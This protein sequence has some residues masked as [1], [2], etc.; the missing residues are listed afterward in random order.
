MLSESLTIV[1]YERDFWTAKKGV[2]RSRQVELAL[3]VELIYTL[4][5]GLCY[6]QRL[7]GS[8]DHK[9]INDLYVSYYAQH[10]CP[11]DY[12]HAQ[13]ELPAIL[14]LNMS[15]HRSREY[16]VPSREIQASGPAIS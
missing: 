8:Q 10:A 12:L 4:G 3:D 7:E 5:L 16:R 15:S 13:T 6:S 9:P 14:D 1:V 11:L 2:V